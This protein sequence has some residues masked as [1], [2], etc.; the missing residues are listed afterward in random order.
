MTHDPLCP[1]VKAC[2]CRHEECCFCDS[3]VWCM[4]DLIAEVRADERGQIVECNHTQTPDNWK[5]EIPYI[6]E[7]L[8]NF[9][10][11]SFVLFLLIFTKESI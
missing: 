3:D 1:S 8:Q 6:K 5:N 7:L 9:Y 2:D 11:N 10:F 4:C